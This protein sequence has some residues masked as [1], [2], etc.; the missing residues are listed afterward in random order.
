MNI[1]KIFLMVL[2]LA[3]LAMFACHKNPTDSSGQGEY[4]C[5]Y[6]REVGIVY[7]DTVSANVKLPQVEIPWP[8]LTNSPWPFSKRTAQCMARTPYKGPRNG[9]IKWQALTP[10]RKNTCPPVIDGDGNIYI[11][12]KC[13]GSPENPGDVYAVDQYGQVKWNFNG[14]HDLE[15]FIGSP[16]I[17]FDGTIYVGSLLGPGGYLYAL[18]SDSTLKWVFNLESKSSQ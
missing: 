16:M 9:E 4:Q 5:K 6:R 18:N 17:D 15:Q 1:K 12:N 2:Q 13:L 8:S 3:L 11:V 10:G 7:F 14:Q